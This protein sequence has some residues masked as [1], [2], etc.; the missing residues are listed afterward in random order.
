MR[1]ALRL[2]QSSVSE[3]KIYNFSDEG[4]KGKLEEPFI[5][6]LDDQQGD[7]ID[8]QLAV[9]QGG[10][11]GENN[12]NSGSQSEARSGVH[13][14]RPFAAMTRAPRSH[15]GSMGAG[16]KGAG[17][18]VI[19]KKGSMMGHGGKGSKK[20]GKGLGGKKGN[21]VA[22]DA[23]AAPSVPPPVTPVASRAP[24][25]EPPTCKPTKARP[26][27]TDITRSPSKSSLPVAPPVTPPVGPKP[28]PSPGPT[29]APASQAPATEA[30]AVGSSRTAYPTPTTPFTRC[31]EADS[32]D[33]G[34]P[35]SDIG[36]KCDK[37]NPAASFSSCMATCMDAFCC[38]HD[39]QSKRATSCSNEKNCVFFDPCYIVWFTLH[40]TIGPAP[41]IRLDQTEPFFDVSAA[42]LEQMFL[43]RPDF[44]DQLF[45]HH[46][47]TDD[48]PLI[49]ATFV[50]PKNW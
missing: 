47:M 33:I 4:N 39:S 28:R 11:R 25:V 26:P 46:F 34:C 36:A 38:I 44:Y 23:P 3:F 27:S 31:F 35:D 20:N 41:Y 29:Q 19:G 16:K 24:V 14:P 12:S 40:D 1:N 9:N 48:L 15:V 49:D 43:D 8:E 21:G 10:T 5:R 2:E 37:Y 7:F 42:D 17:K 50:D 6:G 22:P 45:G 13:G 30:P 18:E 32:P